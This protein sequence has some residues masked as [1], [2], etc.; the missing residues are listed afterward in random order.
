MDG[1]IVMT[2]V[3]MAKR[4]IDKNWDGIKEVDIRT[5]G[6]ALVIAETF[7]KNTK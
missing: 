7:E 1:Y 3:E 6:L 2:A 4:I 5:F